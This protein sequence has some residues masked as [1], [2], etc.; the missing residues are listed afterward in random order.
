MLISSSFTAVDQ[1]RYERLHLT[2][3]QRR[4]ATREDR[5]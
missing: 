4:K 3:C 5:L 1:Q 2:A